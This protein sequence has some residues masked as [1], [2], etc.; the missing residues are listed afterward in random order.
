ML[1]YLEIK[2][3]PKN[4]FREWAVD[5]SLSKSLVCIFKM[6]L[7]PNIWCCVHY[8][9]VLCSYSLCF[10]ANMIL[11]SVLNNRA[12]WGQFFM[13]MGEMKEMFSLHYFFAWVILSVY[14]KV[15]SNWCIL[16]FCFKYSL[17]VN[18]A[19]WIRRCCCFLWF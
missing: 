5:N 12:E 13:E 2:Q 18:K 1:I 6:L 7:G 17:S 19:C 11:Y 9:K 4:N 16:N 15:C 8:S 14:Q 3:L 10:S